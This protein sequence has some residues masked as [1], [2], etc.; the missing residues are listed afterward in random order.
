MNTPLSIETATVISRLFHA[1]GVIRGEFDGITSLDSSD[2]TV[3]IGVHWK[4]RSGWDTEWQT[5]RFTHAELLNETDG[6][7]ARTAV[8]RWHEDKRRDAEEAAARKQRDIERIEAE[9]RAAQ[10]QREAE[11]PAK[12]RALLRELAERYPDELTKTS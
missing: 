7:L 1:I 5:V 9:G 4:E 11:R 6:W 8:E 12:E 3:T 2:D 10:A